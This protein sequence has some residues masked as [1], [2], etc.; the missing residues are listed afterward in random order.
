MAFQFHNETVD[1][2]VIFVYRGS[3]YPVASIQTGGL[4][5]VSPNATYSIGTWDGPG[6]ATPNH[7]RH[8]GADLLHNGM[9]CSVFAMPG[10]AV[11][12]YWRI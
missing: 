1:A 10:L 5:G 9:G 7:R 6:G 2:G 3:S 11:F 12:P 4:G 8:S